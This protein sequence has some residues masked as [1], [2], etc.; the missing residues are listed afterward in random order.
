MCH[1]AAKVE[2][3][4]KR[5]THDWGVCLC[6]GPGPTAARQRSPQPSPGVC[7][8]GSGLGPGDARLGPTLLLW[9][10]VWTDIQPGW[11]VRVLRPA[12]GGV[13]RPGLQ[14]N[15]V[16]LRTNWVRQDVHAGRRTARWALQV[17][18]GPCVLQIW[19]SLNLSFFCSLCHLLTITHNTPMGQL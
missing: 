18:R 8:R 14:R 9:P 1:A 16:L 4:S 19:V 7:A 13:L 2:F 15:C 12:P 5:G 17:V 11:G 6:G 10:R 3:G